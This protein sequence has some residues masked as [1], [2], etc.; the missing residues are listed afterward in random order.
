MKLDRIGDYILGESLGV[1]T[2]GSVF[3]VR[4]AS[5]DEEFALKILLPELSKD[6]SIKARFQRETEVLQRLS[7]PNIVSYYGSGVYQ[8]RL[9]YVMELVEG[10]SLKDILLKQG[11]ISWQDSIEVGWQICSALQHAHNQ[12]IVHRDLKPANLF[13]TKNGKLKLGDFGLA[14]DLAGA[15]LT[16][17]GLTVGT[18]LYMA[19]EQIRGERRISGQT[20]LY[21]LGCLLFRMIAG[22]APFEGQNFAQIFDQHLHSHPPK[23]QIFSP[24][25]PIDLENIIN[26]MLEKE[27]DQRPFNAREVQGELAEILLKWDEDQA[28]ET[29]V[30]RSGTWAIDPNRPILANL[31]K[32]K[33]SAEEKVSWQ[34]LL[35]LFLI[36]I[37][38]LIVL[39]QFPTNEVAP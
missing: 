13:F 30:K 37:V 7:H 18:Y 8:D 12:G 19:P 3:R 15:E 27:P 20:D 39:V 21:A 28:K 34:K 25:C 26:Q 10:G 5:T 24:E 35:I 31:V 2:V 29:L 22:Q 38:V 9:Y 36:L 32:R 14:L 17:A 1:G 23:L 6:E 16:T 33:Q 11:R 4:H